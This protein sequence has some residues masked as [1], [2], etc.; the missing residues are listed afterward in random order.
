MIRR[1]LIRRLFTPAERA[2]LFVVVGDVGKD[3]WD[4][5]LSRH[6]RNGLPEWDE[7]MGHGGRWILASIYKKLGA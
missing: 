2:A 1:F 7:Y 4:R 3:E 5:F 6:P